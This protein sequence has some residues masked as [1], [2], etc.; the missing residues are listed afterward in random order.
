[1]SYQVESKRLRK[2]RVYSSVARLDVKQK[3]VAF[4][5]TTLLSDKVSTTP[6]TLNVSKGSLEIQSKQNGDS[7]FCAN[8]SA[9]TP[10]HRLFQYLFLIFQFAIFKIS[11]THSKPLPS[12]TIKKS[13]YQRRHKKRSPVV[14]GVLVPCIS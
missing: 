1:L 6:E 9:S 12:T 10:L 5:T 13:L 14:S 7:Y 3:T 4:T 2:E 11:K 8:E